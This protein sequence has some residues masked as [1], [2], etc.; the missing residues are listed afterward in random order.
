MIFNFLKYSFWL[1]KIPLEKTKLIPRFS[2][3]N[4]GSYFK[5]GVVWF[6]YL[7]EISGTKKDTFVYIKVTKKEINRIIKNLK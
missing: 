2:Y 6:K 7:F 4:G 3:F 5:I 1:G